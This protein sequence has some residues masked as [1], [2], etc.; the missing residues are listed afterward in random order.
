MGSFMPWA[1]V[2]LCFALGVASRSISDTFVV[3]VPSLQQA[4]DA[5]RGSVTLIYSFALL[6]GGIAA[7]IAGWIVD[8]FGL[9]TLTVIGMTA[10][11]LA[12][13]SASQ[14]TALWHLYF[15]LGIVMGFGAAALSGVLSA[16]LLGRWF[17]SRRLGVAL[18]VAWSASMPLAS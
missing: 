15:G 9:R 1:L 2:A 10:A 12:T 8:R 3:F 14:A 6:V 13:A 16:S 18:A 17:P 5:H 4:F 11:T 7:P